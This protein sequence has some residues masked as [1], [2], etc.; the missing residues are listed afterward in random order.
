SGTLTIG[1][2]LSWGCMISRSMERG[3]AVA[4]AADT[5]TARDAA[6]RQRLLGDLV[7]ESTL[8]SKVLETEVAWIRNRRVAAMGRVGTSHIKYR[9]TDKTHTGAAAAGSRPLPSRACTRSTC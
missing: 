6:K 5:T 3:C 2:T 9:N 8:G 1:M 4:G 7:C